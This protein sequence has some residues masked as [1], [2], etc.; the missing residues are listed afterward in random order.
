MKSATFFDFEDVM[1]DVTRHFKKIDSNQYGLEGV[2]PIVDQSANEICGFTNL[3][4]DINSICPPYIVFGDHTRRIKFVDMDFILGADG[5]K[6]LK[7]KIK[8]DH[9]YLYHC[10]RALKIEEVGY[11][12]HYKFLK[13]FKL[14]VHHLQNNSA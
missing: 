6:V 7:P 11:S 5:T 9:K 13:R 12:R 4:P 10:L 2:T 8:A 14:F 1:E 3:D